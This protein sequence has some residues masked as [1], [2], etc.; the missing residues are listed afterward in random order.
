MFMIIKIIPMF[1]HFL[2]F[3]DFYIFWYIF[4]SL[5]T[6]LCLTFNAESITFHFSAFFLFLLP[7]L[8]WFIFWCS[9]ISSLLRIPSILK[10]WMVFFVQYIC[11][12]LWNKLKHLMSICLAKIFLFSDS[13]LLWCYTLAH[14]FYVFA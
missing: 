13:R 11:Y 5:I 1:R 14:F 6:I 12:Y 9:F 8:L 2:L 4:K 10:M 3:I 7:R